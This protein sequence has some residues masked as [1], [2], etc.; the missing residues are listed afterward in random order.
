MCALYSLGNVAN[1]LLILSQIGIYIQKNNQSLFS[2]D[3][4]RNLF[5]LVA[6][7][8]IIFYIVSSHFAYESYKEF[9]RISFEIF[10][11]NNTEYSEPDSTEH[12]RDS[13]V[14]VAKNIEN[15]VNNGDSIENKEMLLNDSNDS[16][17]LKCFENVHSFGRFKHQKKEIK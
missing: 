11:Q 14:K 10:L 17:N 2:G 12:R 4:T 16:N 5:Y 8:S 9:K 3:P 13:S 1:S 7:L 15:K 6:A